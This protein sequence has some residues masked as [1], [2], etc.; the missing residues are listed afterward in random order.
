MEERTR[1]GGLAAAVLA[2]GAGAC[3]LIGGIDDKELVPSGEATSSA[4]SGAMSSGVGT[5]ASGSASGSSAVT[6]GGDGGGGSGGAEGGASSQSASSGDAT[7]SSTT[8]SGSGIACGGEPPVDTCDAACGDTQF[9]PCNC[10][11][12][13]HS[14]WGGDC[15]AGECRPLVIDV[16]MG[17]DETTEG[18]LD[19]IGSLSCTDGAVY[20]TTANAGRV[21]RISMEAVPTVEIIGME[22]DSP[23]YTAANCDAVYYVSRDSSN[24]P[25]GV[26]T[27]DGETF[28]L[29]EGGEL[30][31]RWMAATSD[32]VFWSEGGQLPGRLQMWTP[33]P[34]DPTEGE[35]ETIFDS[36]VAWFVGVAADDTHVFISLYDP[37]TET[38]S[39]RR[40]AY[41]ESNVPEPYLAGRGGTFTVVDDTHFYW[42][43]NDAGPS[44][45]RRK[46]KNED[47]PDDEGE[48]YVVGGDVG[49]GIAVDDDYV[50]WLTDA[51][52][53]YARKDDTTS[54]DTLV[55]LPEFPAPFAGQGLVACGG[56]L[57]IASYVTCPRVMRLPKPL[58]PE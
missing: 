53:K 48:A 36:D 18:C 29:G 7:T 16:P 55:E 25:R 46:P 6:T 38:S 51:E 11:S 57:F 28:L 3:E 52:L 21:Y 15:D 26:A 44:D 42:Y 14:C 10:G 54:T 2:L 47:A 56:F 19:G 17:L 1:L 45:V 39:T 12:C 40:I 50:Y 43:T 9:D 24:P 41:R 30:F 20:V 4:A 34:D 37:G 22:S 23:Y 33:D 13:G 32:R 8:T 35:V 58:P 49:R 27:A 5:P 31:G